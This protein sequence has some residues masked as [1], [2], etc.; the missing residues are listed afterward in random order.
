MTTLRRF[1]QVKL[2]KVKVLKREDYTPDLM[3][4]WVEK[5]EGYTFKAGQYCTIGIDGI[6]RADSIASAPYEDSLE[7]F[8]ELVH[9]EE[10][11]ELVRQLFEQS[12]ARPGTDSDDLA[13]VVTTD[14]QRA[15]IC[16]GKGAHRLQV[17]VA[18]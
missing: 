2:S 16:V 1:R 17:V 4:L 5:P 9:P 7:L 12:S 15:A 8:V 6:D 3:L 10:V 14:L 13:F 11:A 18:P